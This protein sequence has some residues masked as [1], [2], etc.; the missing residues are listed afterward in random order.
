MV[1]TGGFTATLGGDGSRTAETA[2]VSVAVTD[3]CEAPS[4]LGSAVS[5]TETTA[6]MAADHHAGVVRVWAHVVW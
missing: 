2:D 6:V 4:A 1:T 3:R 5:R